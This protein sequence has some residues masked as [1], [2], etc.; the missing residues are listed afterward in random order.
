MNVNREAS[1]GPEWASLQRA[2]LTNVYAVFCKV[3]LFHLLTYPFGAADS[4]SPGQQWNS[5]NKLAALGASVPPQPHSWTA[6]INP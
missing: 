5:L 4:V 3:M 1:D 2:L 6:F